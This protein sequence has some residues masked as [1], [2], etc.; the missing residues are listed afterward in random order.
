M[1]ILIVF[2]KK[3]NVA[4]I[5][6][7]PPGK[8]HL[9]NSLDAIITSINF[10]V[11]SIGLS[12]WKA[13]IND[14]IKKVT[15]ARL[16]SKLSQR[17]HARDPYGISRKGAPTANVHCKLGL[18][19]KIR[20]NYIRCVLCS[21][22]Q[23]F[24]SLSGVFTSAGAWLLWDSWKH[25]QV[26]LILLLWTCYGQTLKCPHTTDCIQCL[27]PTWHAI[28]GG[29]GSFRRKGLCEAGK[30]LLVSLWRCVLSSVSFPRLVS[31]EQ[32]VPTTVRVCPG[33]GASSL[34]LISVK[35]WDGPFCFQGVFS[36]SLV[37]A[38]QR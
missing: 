32:H 22:G 5:S 31:D 25:H 11:P 7:Y 21:G 1:P 33:M 8:F 27:V 19:H 10:T 13:C 15:N 29:A 28:M 17:H 12:Q 4:S 18:I 35:L 38:R 24:N 26:F 3:K 23:I 20:T 37:T 14:L 34:R 36:S 30:Q 6:N 16:G 2:K 9:K